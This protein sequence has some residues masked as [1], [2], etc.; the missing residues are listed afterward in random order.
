MASPEVS[1]GKWN[2]NSAM[3]RFLFTV[4]LLSLGIILSLRATWML[5]T[6][7]DVPLTSRSLF[8]QAIE[9]IAGMSAVVAAACAS[10][11]SRASTRIAFVLSVGLAVFYSL[12]TARPSIMQ[13]I[14]G[15]LGMPHRDRVHP[16]AQF[17]L[18]L[19][20][21]ISEQSKLLLVVA[22]L[23]CILLRIMLQ[24]PGSAR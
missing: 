7:T 8:P 21:D 18:L 5:L 17:G 11:G 3:R 22:I 13:V 1:I 23:S 24:N 19:H 9:I 6:F 16:A 20:S 2:S 14:I 4:P 15:F 12:R 10:R